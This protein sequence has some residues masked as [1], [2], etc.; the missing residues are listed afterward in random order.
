MPSDLKI[1]EKQA[2]ERALGLW[3]WR[4]PS[5]AGVGQSLA[6]ARGTC[7]AAMPLQRPSLRGDRC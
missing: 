6:S 5:Q 4:S 3:G 1:F 7:P 2:A